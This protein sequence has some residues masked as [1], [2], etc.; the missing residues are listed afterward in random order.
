MHCG[1]S[2]ENL[3]VGIDGVCRITD[4]GVARQATGR[5]SN[6]VTHGEA[7]YLAP[8]RLS[9]GRL[10][11]RADVFSIGIVLYQALTGV[12]VF[13]GA[14]VQETLNLVRTRRIE[15]PSS[16][17]LR[18]P[19]GL[20]SEC[21]SA[22]ERDADRR[23]A[24][25]QEMMLELRRIALRENLLAPTSGVARAVKDAVEPDLKHRRSIVLEG[26]HRSGATAHRQPGAAGPIE[27]SMPRAPGRRRAACP[28]RSL[29]ASPRRSPNTSSSAPPPGRDSSA[30]PP[31]GD[32]IVV[33]AAPG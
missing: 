11:C 33:E 27:S 28:R 5:D 2:P 6:K 19:P 31:N 15:P 13:E 24:S 22:L 25:A 17:G 12:K 18:P 7:S 9:N 16:V 4:L 26:A 8:E 3:I 20:N 14:G 29:R 21:L 23:F 10:G 32:Q 30:P 1:V